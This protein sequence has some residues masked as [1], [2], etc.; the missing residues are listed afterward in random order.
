MAVSAGERRAAAADGARLAVE[1][2]RDGTVTIHL[3]GVWTLA[4]GLPDSDQVEQA[5]TQAPPARTVRFD[6]EGLEHWDTGVLAFLA[7]VEDLA[8]AR[9][10]SVDRGGLPEPV[11]RLLTLAEA[12]PEKQ[13]ARAPESA[14]SL[15]TRV[16][17]GTQRAWDQTVAAVTFFGEATL[18]LLRFVTGRARFRWRDL[19]VVVQET[20]IEALPI[21][22]LINFLVGMIIAFVGAV[23]LQKFG[24]G[25][26]VADLVTIATARELGCLMT[27]V[28]MAGRTG[29]GFAAQLGTMQVN[30]EI[31][32]LET[33][34]LAPMDFLVLPRIL[35]LVLMMPLLSIYAD[36]IGMLGGAF[37][38]V[39]MLDLTPTQFWLEAKHSIDLTDLGLGISKSVVFGIIIAIA[40]CMQGMHAGRNAA[41]VGQAATSAVVLSIVWIVVADGVFAVLTNILGI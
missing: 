8:R 28:I 9:K 7:K 34:G 24:A 23:Q 5:L 38:A 6:L 35:A 13:D 25:I 17:L 1:R 37:V 36:V 41:A 29:S 39:G 20:G 32:A 14:A 33:M 12:V 19:W 11:Q 4:K 27:A 21:V 18:A 31:E 10:V 3:A 26:Y 22:T 30:Q 2:G 15:V 40:G 16:G